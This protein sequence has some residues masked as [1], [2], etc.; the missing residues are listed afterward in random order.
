MTLS[1]DVAALAWL[2]PRS[3]SFWVWA[4]DGQCLT[5]RDGPLIAFRRELY[6]L[7]ESLA[8]EG[9][10]PCGC[11][12]LL[13][14]ACRDQRDDVSL[15]AREFH[16]YLARPEI[17]ATA[18]SPW[19]PSLLAGLSA[20]GHLPAEHRNSLESRALL[21]G[22]L[23]EDVR[24]RLDPATSQRVLR[25][26]RE[27]WPLT[28]DNAPPEFGGPR[29][30]EAVARE[31]TEM[32]R[33]V[34]GLE[35][36]ELAQR[37]TWGFDGD[38]QA[39][40]LEL[41]L[42]QT[43]AGLLRQLEDDTE[44]H[45]IAAIARSLQAVFEIPRP[46]L[47]PEEL[48]VGGISDLSNRGP[49]DRLLLSELAHENDTLMAR[50]A[51][52]EALY[53]RRE[54][55]AQAPIRNR[56]LLLDSGI[57][58][59][60]LPRV[61]AAG[62]ALAL[63]AQTEQDAECTV[64]VA[65]G[66]APE[67]VDLTTREGL[68]EHLARLKVGLHPGDAF[69][70]LVARIPADQPADVIVVGEE[71]SL[72][73]HDYVQQVQSR[74]AAGRPLSQVYQAAVHRSGRTRLSVRTAAGCRQL[75]EVQLDLD[76]LLAPKKKATAPGDSLRRAG[77]D[78]LPAIIPV[79]PFPLLLPHHLEIEEA[80]LPGHDG[81][82]LCRPRDRRL[83]LWENPRQAGMMLHDSLPAGRLLW[84]GVAAS[85][86]VA[87]A[88]FGRLDW[89]TPHLVRVK[90][91]DRTVE[92]ESLD[93][94][95]DKA[96]GVTSHLGL[97]MI[98][99]KQ[100]I[101]LVSPETGVLLSTTALAGNIRWVSGRFFRQN[102]HWLAASPGEGGV[103][104]EPV[105]GTH[106]VHCTSLYDHPQH[107]IIGI[108]PGGVLKADDGTALSSR[109]IHWSPTA[110]RVSCD[111]QRFLFMPLRAGGFCGYD[112]EADSDFTIPSLLEPA[113]DQL[114][115]RQTR[116]RFKTVGLGPDGELWLWPTRNREPVRLVNDG[117]KGRCA[118]AHEGLDGN[119]KIT[120][121][122]IPAEPPPAGRRELEPTDAPAGSGW[123][124][125][126]ATFS[127]GSR[128]WLD[129][130]GM[131]HFRSSNPKIPEA[132]IILPVADSIAGWMA[133]GEVWGPDYYL[134]PDV[135][136]HRVP[137]NDFAQ[138]CLE[139]FIEHVLRSLPAPVA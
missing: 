89:L 75:K 98:V 137:Y 119:S 82:V 29:A 7:L 112:L 110:R 139:P 90:L 138:Q 93:V 132:T 88:V 113:F 62:V 74:L 12:V 22:I 37:L 117:M 11:L 70:N 3:C 94:E 38:L 51:L 127:D 26:L 59:W 53:L 55:P 116:R 97:L 99:R 78:A 130:R 77:H 23:L 19:V 14:A 131:L 69:A 4:D 79:R 54:A 13:L 58:L 91:R 57:R 46:M 111:G 42:K 104:L 44:F 109:K 105:P 43:A 61:F 85:G 125:K 9:L 134:T 6:H 84:S 56:W 72:N 45:G 31:L 50:V 35:A 33:V 126:V 47:H 73:D 129:S 41:P 100:Q 92:I 133:T 136:R 65:E 15:V 118:P 30:S 102:Q 36:D 27:G 24:D 135:R 81:P 1:G 87:L 2:L 40:D 83:M 39:P 8:D 28:G 49:L 5:W 96:L 63:A 68:A 18:D 80:W 52:G 10:P 25:I 21:A 103:V 124:L 67:P 114:E 34:N 76:S 64:F 122:A 108:F 20:I 121:L 60:G 66:T 107:G 115:N 86:K 71:S 16:R 17:T 32:H 95:P 123:S 128:I 48:P 106:V 101:D 120:D